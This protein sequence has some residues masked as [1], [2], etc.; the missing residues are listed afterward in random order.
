M[1][2]F[3]SSSGAPLTVI[4]YFPSGN[5]LT[6]DISFRSE[7]NGTS[8]TRWYWSITA[9]L[10]Y[11]RWSLNA[12]KA[13]SVG[14]PTNSSSI[15]FV[16]LFKIIRSNNLDWKS[17][18]TVAASISWLSTKSFST[19]ILFWVR[20][21]VLSEAMI[22]V[23]PK[24]STA[25]SFRI[26]AWRLTIRWVPKARVIVT[27][28]GKPSG[29]AA[30][31]SEIA[32]NNMSIKLSWPRNIPTANTTTAMAKIN[33]VNV[34][35][36]LV[37]LR[38]KGV[39]V[40]SASLINRA[41]FPTSVAIPVWMTIPFPRPKVTLLFIKARLVRSP[42]GS[43]SSSRAAVCLF[44]GTD[45]PVN[46][47][48]SICIDAD[49]TSRKSAGTTSPASK[50]TTSPGTN[51]VLWICCIWPS[52]STLACGAAKLFNASI[53]SSALDSWKTP[54]IAFNTTTSKIIKASTPSPTNTE[55]KAATSSTMIIKSL[56]WAKNFCN[57]VVLPLVASSLW[58]YF[59][60][61]RCASAVVS[62]A[63][64]VSCLAAVSSTVRCQSFNLLAFI[65][66]PPFNWDLKV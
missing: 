1:V 17:G 47:D 2:R 54:K 46:A 4:K 27:I 53:A 25:G 60:N 51:S 62:P 49:S 64:R 66:F 43:C 3:K 9:A 28:A 32:V 61:R 7:S 8:A 33:Q 56:N 44:T 10:E 35:L 20:V 5:A 52:R 48:S 36:S 18:V 6:V 38:C 45:S 30:T 65:L 22:C 13:V 21:P 24:V 55:I 50:M 12:I 42:R 31:A 40:S 58:P 29:M 57:K 15:F 19:V 34:L 23:L 37:K 11:P 41:I 39:M 26:I 63:N 59:S 16:S 14:S